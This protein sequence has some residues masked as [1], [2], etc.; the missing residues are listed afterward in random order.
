MSKSLVRKN[1]AYIKYYG[2]D[3]FNLNSNYNKNESN[4]NKIKQRKQFHLQENTKENLFNIRKQKRIKRD[5]LKKKDIIS[6]SVEKKRKNPRESDIFFLKRYNSCERRKGVKFIPDILNRKTI[7]YNIRNV[8]DYTNYIKNYELIHRDNNNTYNPDIYINRETPYERYFRAYYNDNISTNNETN[9]KDELLKKYLHDRKFLKNEI[10][11]LNDSA[12]EIKEASINKK[13]YRQIKRNKSEEKR[14]FVDS[15]CFPRYN[16]NINRQIQMESNIFNNNIKKEK[17]YFQEAKEI[18]NRI[19]KAN[20][21]QNLTKASN[22]NNTSIK[23]PNNNI[24]L[25]KNGI[26]NNTIANIGK[27][28]NLYDMNKF[29]KYDLITGKQ[30]IEK[31][32]VI[33][34][35]TEQN[36]NKKLQEMIES[37]PNLSTQ[38]K[39][40]IKMK[41]SVLDFNEEKDLSQKCKE[42]KDFYK[43]DNSI[44]KRRKK[45]ITL[46]INDKNND[47]IFN[48][49][50]L[51]KK[52]SEKYVM[53]YTSKTKFDKFDSNEIKNIFEKKG[54]QVYDIH[55][56]NTY[57]GANLNVVS[58]KLKGENEKRIQSIEND[59][60]KE[61][62]KVK[63]KKDNKLNKANKEQINKN[64]EEKRFKIMPKEIIQLR[65]F[66]KKF[67]KY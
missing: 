61:N 2:S 54:V 5:I 32:P 34:K 55:D 26:S 25:E 43:C 11:K 48:D 37:I 33:K 38:N 16:C 17:D 28:K 35:T 13:R 62:Y 57:N 22:I 45:D 42:L 14:F 30:I 47:I 15:K 59:L 10:M 65:G 8:D 19:E 66:T 50:K 58:F 52:P 3:I 49:D 24:K 18:Y 56:K 46:K 40:R 29:R 31:I 23:I 4:K 9:K 20:K 36:E 67:G 60:K 64:K 12:S 21:R 27:I 53:T 7:L 6:K 63:I 51:N 41:T 39:L 1:D 44:R